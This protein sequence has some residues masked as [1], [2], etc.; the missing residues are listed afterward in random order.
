MH[1][2]MPGL[3]LSMAVAR[4]NPQAIDITMESS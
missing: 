2:I 3:C 1:E 4:P